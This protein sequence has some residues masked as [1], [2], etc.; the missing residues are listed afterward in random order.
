MGNEGVCLHRSGNK[1]EKGTKQQALSVHLRVNDPFALDGKL[2]HGV[3]IEA[4]LTRW[5]GRD[6]T[7]QLLKNIAIQQLGSQPAIAD[8]VPS[9]MKVDVT[10]DDEIQDTKLWRGTV[11]PHGFWPRYIRSEMGQIE[12]ARVKVRLKRSF[13]WYAVQKYR[14]A[15]KRRRGNAR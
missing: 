1:K 11:F 12:V 2:S 4:A 10:A 14:G 7:E 5:H 13:S 8:S 3:R 15:R 9:S 6:F